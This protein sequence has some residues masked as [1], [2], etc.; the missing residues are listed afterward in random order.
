MAPL[1][2]ILIT[3]ITGYLGSHIATYLVRRGFNVIGLKRTTSSVSRLRFIL[4][5]ITLFDIDRIDLDSFFQPDDPFDAIIHTATCYGR[6]NESEAQILSANLVYPLSI[7][8]KGLKNNS[9]LFINCDS[10]LESNVNSYSLSKKQF[11]EWGK[12]YTR[13][14]GFSFVNIKLEHFFGPNDSRSKF[15]SMVIEKCMA[16]EPSLNLTD[17]SQLRDFIYID[18]VVSAF[19]YILESR[20]NSY[21]DG[22]IEFE[23]GRGSAISVRDFVLSV[24]KQTCSKTTLNFGCIPVRS[25]DSLIYQ[26]NVAKLRKLGWRP[27]FSVSEGIQRTIEL[28]AEKS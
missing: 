16:N 19:S 24:H 17:G 27:R 8:S 18:D 7:M 9:R 12:R 15:T 5:Q 4:D 23:I 10:F 20:N 22:F 13:T 14:K 21:A 2:K 1:K 11:L 25:A 28:E 26:A 3:G 6:N